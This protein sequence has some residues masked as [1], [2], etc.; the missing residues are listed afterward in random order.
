MATAQAQRNL[1]L[2]ATELAVEQ[3]SKQLTLTPEADRALISE[4]IGQAQGGKN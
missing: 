2:F 1:R 3:A 4:F